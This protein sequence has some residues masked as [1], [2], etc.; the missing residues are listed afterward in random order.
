MFVGAGYSS[1]FLLNLSV[2]EI[3]GRSGSRPVSAYL[4]IHGAWHG[5]WCWR[6]V[7]TTLRSCGHEVYTPT[8]TG[9]GERAHLATPE[10]DL[11]THTRDVLGVLTYSDLKDVTLVGHSY[12]GMVITAVAEHASSRLT[13]LIYV[14]AQVPQNNQSLASLAQ[15][16][17]VTDILEKARIYGEGWRVPPLPLD[18]LGIT[19]QED[20]QWVRS[21]LVDQP[22][23]TLFQPARLPNECAESMQRTYVYCSKP[24]LGF[25]E[26]FAKRAQEEGWPYYDLPTGHDAM[27]TAP[28]ELSNILLTSKR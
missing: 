18:K 22:I 9:L 10:I 4:L 12:G 11:E 7:A 8:L 19:A 14:D 23:R 21:K 13:R 16:A 6:R 15:P 17:A 5:G 3:H 20:I 24:P 25:F 26:Q 2:L 27:I 28:D 1:F